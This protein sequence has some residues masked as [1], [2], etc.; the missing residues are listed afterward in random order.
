MTASEFLYPLCKPPKLFI[1]HSS[2]L[3]N[4]GCMAIVVLILICEVKCGV[5][6]DQL[7][8]PLKIFLDVSMGKRLKLN[9]SD[10]LL[11]GGDLNRGLSLDSVKSSYAGL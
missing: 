10:I 11:I 2:I 8:E 5:I 6:I 1:I 9:L 7:W 4:L 3:Y